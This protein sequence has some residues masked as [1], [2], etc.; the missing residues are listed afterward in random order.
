MAPGLVTP[1]WE[2]LLEP[3]AEPTILILDHVDVNRHLLKAI[4]KAAPYR[5]VEAR[6]AQDAL[7]VLAREKIDLVILDFMMPGMSGPDFCRTLKAD[8]RTQLIPILMITSVQGV[9]NEVASIASGADEFLIKPLHPAVVRTRV[10]AMLRSK[11]AIDS[12]EEAETI[13]FALA[14]AVEQRDRY[15]AGHCQRLAWYGVSLGMALGLPR[16]QLLALH[17]GGFLHDIGKISVPDSILQKRGKL[18][19]EE[20]RIVRM[21]PV[22]GEDICRPMKSLASVLPVIRSHHERWDGGG[23]PDGLP[24][25]RIP[26]VAR[27]L[28][29]ADIYDALIT[30]RPYKAALDPNAALKVLNAE[31]A[32]GWR[33]SHLVGL[34]TELHHGGLAEAGNPLL[35]SWPQL[36]EMGA[37]IAHAP[38]PLAI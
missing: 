20:W 21:H 10:R 19:E 7:A 24:G 17:R 36:A 8:R 34:F 28:Q 14:Q 22:T 1:A 9:E 6:R 18:T 32:R 26:L 2:M 31:A 38:Q 15:T 11:A 4:L 13:L 23:Y 27:I 33:D 12:L 3:E 37:A 30:E 35:L 29:V 25:E 5:I 16:P